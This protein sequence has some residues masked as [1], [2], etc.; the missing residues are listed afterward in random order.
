MQNVFVQVG[1]DRI[2]R[3]NPGSLIPNDRIWID[4]LLAGGGVR[5]PVSDKLY[6]V[7]TGLWNFNNN[8]YGED[9]NDEEGE[10]PYRGSNS[11]T[12]EKRRFIFIF[13]F[14]YVSLFM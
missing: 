13:V 3:N 6:V 2:N 8:Q 14:D 4:N 12:G 9:S 5:Y 11:N 10:V 1:W 7:A